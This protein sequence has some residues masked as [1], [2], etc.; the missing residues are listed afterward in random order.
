MTVRMTFKI[1][2]TTAGL[3]ILSGCSRAAYEAEYHPRYREVPY[4]ETPLVVEPALTTEPEPN[5][6]PEPEIYPEPEPTIEYESQTQ[7]EPQTEPEIYREAEIELAR[8]STRFDDSDKNRNHNMALAAASLNNKI[9]APGETFSYNEAL[10]PTTKN[11]G[12]KKGVIFKGGRKAKGY[13]GGVCQV[14]STLYNAVASAGLT[15]V[16]RHAHS[17]KVTYIEA[18]RDA[19]T[20]Y[21]TLDFKF[22][23]DKP[24]PIMINSSAENGMV[25]V[26][27][28]AI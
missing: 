22:K 12:Y 25:S 9:V 5:E 2:L 6:Q 4:Y 11:R 13:G 8:F 20:S 18:G 15:I 27:V 26:V 1:L 24:F 28:K 23:N 10:G 3:I 21:G 14:S 7:T 19:A 16:E 17:G